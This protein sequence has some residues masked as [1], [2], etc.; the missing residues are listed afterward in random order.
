M[1]RTIALALAALPLLARSSGPLPTFRLE[2]SYPTNELTN[3][4]FEV[5][6]SPDPGG[7]NWQLLAIAP[8]TNFPL[9]PTGQADFFKVRASNVVSGMT[10]DWA[11]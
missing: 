5:W 10:S 1:K 4:V 8:S 2:W 11:H 6:H 7:T 3:I 9:M